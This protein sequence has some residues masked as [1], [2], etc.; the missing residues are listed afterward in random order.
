MLKVNLLDKEGKKVKDIELND[1]IFGIKPND[2]VIYDA[3]V[4]AAASAR[5]GTAKAKNRSEVSGGGKKPW[6]QKGTGRARQGSIRSPQWVG[7]GVV[8]GPTP[9]SYDKKQNKK[10]RRLALKSVLSY[11]VIDNQFL[12]VDALTDTGKTKEFVAYLNSL[13]TGKSVLVVT[14]DLTE[15]LIL[16]SRNLNDV[17]VIR[18]DEINT[19]DVV[20]YETIIITAEAVKVLE[21]VL[22]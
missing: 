7:G 12:V 4:L 6:K 1:T 2:A 3:V 16:A 17:K 20:S 15:N 13:N 9:R 21:E 11:K 19:Y 5:Q 18:V 22:A 14:H 10:E 8:F